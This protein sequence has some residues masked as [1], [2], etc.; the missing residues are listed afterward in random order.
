[1][2]QTGNGAAQKQGMGQ[3][4]GRGAYGRGEP[5]MANDGL[6]N[7]SRRMEWGV[8]G[9]AGQIAGYLDGWL[10]R[11]DGWKVDCGSTG[12]VVIPVGDGR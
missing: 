6:V 12:G 2:K 3:T 1:M 11:W 10:G 7:L 4:S 8:P 9:E 5:R